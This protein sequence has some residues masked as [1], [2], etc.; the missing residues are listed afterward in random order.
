MRPRQSITAVTLVSSLVVLATGCGSDDKPPPAT[1]VN[2]STTAGTRPV[3]VLEDRSPVDS[4]PAY[5]VAS[6]HVQSAPALANA[7]K[8]YVPALGTEIDVRRIAA[9]MLYRGF[10]GKIVDFD[11]PVDAAIQLQVTS[12]KSKEPRVLS[13]WGVQDVDLATALQGDARVE[14]D[15][16]GV[17]KLI[18]NEPNVSAPSQL[19]EHCLVVPSLGPAKRRLVCGDGPVTSE[20]LSAASAWLARGITQRPETTSALHGEVDMVALRK[21]Y[22][23]E[24]QKARTQG[25]AMVIPELKIGKSAIDAVIKKIAMSAIDD[26]F[27]FIEDLQTVTFDATLRDDSVTTNLD[28]LLASEKS[29]MAQLLLAPPDESTPTSLGKL[30]STGSFLGLFSRASSARDALLAPVQRTLVALVEATSIDLQWPK[31]DKDLALDWLKAAFPRTAD[32]V[33]VSGKGSSKTPVN[34]AAPVV[35]NIAHRSLKHALEQSTWTMGQ[36]ARE[37]KSTID[38]IKATGALVSRPSFATALRALLKDSLTFKI[39]SKASSPKGLTKETF[40]QT[41]NVE[42]NSLEPPSKTGSGAEGTDGKDPKDAKSVKKKETPLAKMV[43]EMVVVADGP[44][45][46]FTAVG[47]NVPEADLIMHLKNMIEGGPAVTATF[48][49]RPGYAFITQDNAT[50]GMIMPIDGMVQLLPPARSSLSLNVTA[51][52]FL[53]K[54]PDHGVSNL[55]LRSTSTKAGAGGTSEVALMIPR[56]MVALMLELTRMD[57]PKKARP[58]LP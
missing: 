7:L 3:K 22:H 15:A 14:T 49:Q 35:P 51:E 57:S 2:A 25:A 42:V 31:T 54:L 39:T 58:A 5:I 56:D 1:P 38:L 23:D 30:P 18:A 47:H 44:N 26:T 48:A 36:A 33:S 53:E 16:K 17:I 29:W 9:K 20:E 10:L 37:A 6:L 19:S 46:T 40:A 43:A 34:A 11:K 45:N 41:F 27:D 8:S 21:R 50:S 28:V 12:S 24:L 13:A 4:P 32:S 52:E 55:A